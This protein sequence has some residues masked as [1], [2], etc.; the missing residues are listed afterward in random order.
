MKDSKITVHIHSWGQ[1]WTRHKNTNPVPPH[2]K[3]KNKTKNPTAT[4]KD[5]G[6]KLWCWEQNQVTLRAPCIYTTKRVGKPC[7]SSLQPDSWDPP[8]LSPHQRNSLSRFEEQAR[9][10][11]IVF[12]PPTPLH[13]GHNKA[14]PEFLV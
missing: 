11:I 4:S 8:L 10:P 13:Q 12:T 1:L 2:L 7:K 14:L 3:N 9:E 6:A 5:L